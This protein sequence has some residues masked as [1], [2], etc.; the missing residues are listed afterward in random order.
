MNQE[1]YKIENNVRKAE[2]AWD[3]QMKREGHLKKESR[4]ISTASAATMS[5]VARAFYNDYKAAL[6]QLTG[7]AGA[8]DLFGGTRA[9]PPSF[10]DHKNSAPKAKKGKGHLS[11]V[12]A[13]TPDASAIETPDGM[14]RRIVSVGALADLRKMASGESLMKAKPAAKVY[15]CDGQTY[16]V[17]EST[18]DYVV[19]N[20]CVLHDR[21]DGQTVAS[22]GGREAGDWCG[23]LFKG[24]DASGT[25]EYV[26]QS[27]AQTVACVAGD[28]LAG[29]GLETGTD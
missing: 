25:Q 16:V 20:A 4:D 26:M 1:L 8:P 18:P 3:R 17:T 13:S 22:M 15:D 2:S 6:G 19:L 14:T 28:P 12:S 27:S 24:K 11:V 10:G 23:L 7:E 29:V 21:W 9:D 5:P